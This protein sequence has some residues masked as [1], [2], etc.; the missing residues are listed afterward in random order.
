MTRA[1]SST[2]LSTE[3]GLFAILQ[4]M[5][6][7]QKPM[8]SLVIPVY[9][10]HAGL[11][12]FH[13]S[14]AEVLEKLSMPYEVIYCDDGSTDGSKDVLA[15]IAANDN[16]VKTIV[17][18][19][20]FGKE[21][22]LSAGIIQAKGEAIIT[23][24]ADG[25]HPVELIPKFVD[26]WKSGARVVVGIRK[27]TNGNMLKKLE[28]KLF[29]SVFNKLSSQKLIPG[30]TDF[31]LIDQSVQS[32][33]LELGES[34]RMT[35]A[36]IDWLGFES[37]YIKFELNKRMQGKPGYSQRKLLQLAM[38]SIVS[39]SP[40]PLYILGYLGMIVTT[41]AL[42]LGLTVIVEQIILGD[43]MHLRITGTAMLGILLLFF[44]GILLISQGVLAIYI[45]HIHTE[46][47]HRPLYVIDYLHSKRIG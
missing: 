34:N 1:P 7:Q 21:S 14:L 4:G 29:Y 24:D 19:R 8:L 41:I 47:K 26:A 17:F 38:N 25:Q 30:S 13:S 9:N 27:S 39:L 46:S 45:S 23:I 36:L 43:P 15:T 2:R 32:A 31:R 40:R 11:Q 22:A 35:R 42:L 33:F 12:A 28:S 6:S 5:T 37:T 18:S 10:E 16:A 44:V 3:K 20:N